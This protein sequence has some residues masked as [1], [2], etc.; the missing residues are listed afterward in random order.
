MEA[1][2]GLVHDRMTCDEYHPGEGV[3]LVLYITHFICFQAVLRM[4]HVCKT[5]KLIPKCKQ[6]AKGSA[7]G[8]VSGCEK[9]TTKLAPHRMAR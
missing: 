5:T 9:S 8:T 3:P 6:A 4:S 1:L 2:R 7:V